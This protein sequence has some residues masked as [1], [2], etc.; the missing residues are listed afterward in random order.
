MTK[1]IYL[2]KNDSDGITK[3]FFRNYLIGSL[4][5]LSHTDVKLGKIENSF[6]LDENYIEFC[7]IEF[8]DRDK[9]NSSL[10]SATYK[11]INRK[12]IDFHKSIA[13]F[14]INF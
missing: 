2:L 8:P 5:D 13:V 11:D 12:L 4:S 7:E 6:L 3:E 9:M 1:I 10:S 14:I